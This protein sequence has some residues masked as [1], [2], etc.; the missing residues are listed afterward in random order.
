MKR[1]KLHRVSPPMTRATRALR[2][3]VTV[4]ERLLWGKLRSCQLSGVKFRRQ[5]P[6]GPYV[7]DFLCVDAGLVIELDGHSHDTTATH[8]E[9]RERF[10]REQGLHVIHFRNDDV[11]ADIASVLDTIANAV[12]VLQRKP[13]R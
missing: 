12:D 7:T 8:D 13:R 1:Q 4:P 9:K 5:Q 3:D 2:K 10:L 6:I 11:I